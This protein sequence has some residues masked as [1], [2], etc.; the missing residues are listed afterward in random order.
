VRS[1]VE[2]EGLGVLWA[3]H[4]FDE[5]RPTDHV[6]VLHKGKVLFNGSVPE[7]LATTGSHNVS[8]AFRKITGTTATDLAA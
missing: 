1:L 2:K 8:D 7:L 6:V 4:L 5:V 3:T